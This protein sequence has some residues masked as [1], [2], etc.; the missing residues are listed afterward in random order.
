M[1]KRINIYFFFLRW[2]VIDS[3]CFVCFILFAKHFF[4]RNLVVK[5]ANGSKTGWKKKGKNWGGGHQRCE[6]VYLTLCISSG[7]FFRV[8]APAT[9][10]GDPSRNSPSDVSFDEHQREREARRRVDLVARKNRSRR[11]L[12]PDPRART[13]QENNHQKGRR[14]KVEPNSKEVAAS[15]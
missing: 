12:Q 4:G 11:D 7:F 8:V 15:S 14:D 13:P 1:G 6:P 2:I 9:S 10:G 3:K 5:D